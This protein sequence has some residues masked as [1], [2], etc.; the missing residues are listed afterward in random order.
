MSHELIYDCR[1]SDRF[2]EKF[3]EDYCLVQDIVFKNKYS[4]KL[5][6]KKFI[7]NI[8]GPSIIIIVYD[9]NYP[10]GA[11]TF[12]RNDIDGKEAYQPGDVC[13]MN[14]YRGRGIFTVMTQKAFA[15]ISE[16]AVIYTYPNSNSFPAHLKMG[17]KLFASYYPALFTHNRY[18][19]E[20]SLILDNEYTRWWLSSRKDIKYIKRREKY[21]L[22]VP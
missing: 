21:Y 20:H 5:F 19:K 7:D 13:V 6:K 18:H 10:I 9:N 8:Y 11:R 16:G 22:I 17:N 4:K 15:M 1:W 14:E 2:D 3:I 12:W